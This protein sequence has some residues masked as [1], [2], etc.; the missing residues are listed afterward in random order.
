MTNCPDGRP[1]NF[2]HMVQ[3]HLRDT[4]F[5]EAFYEVWIAKSLSPA[6]SNSTLFTRV[7]SFH[8]KIESLKPTSWNKR[9]HEYSRGSSVSHRNHHPQRPE[10][11]WYAYIDFDSSIS[12]SQG[13]TIETAS[14][15]RER[16]FLYSMLCVIRSKM[17]SDASR[18]QCKG[19]FV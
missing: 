5:A 7:R 6:S 10:F 12:F 3:Q 18:T 2:F 17:T 14:V 19:I 1:S 11:A 4:G 8:T 13:T 9:S 15:E 16:R